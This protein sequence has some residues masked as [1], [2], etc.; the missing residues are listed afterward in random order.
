MEKEYSD[1]ALPIVEGKCPPI[2]EMVIENGEW[3][4]RWYYPEPDPDYEDP[5]MIETETYYLADKEEYYYY[6]TVC[7][8]CGTQ[9]QAYGKDNKNIRNYC[10]GCGKR[11]E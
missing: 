2:H 8:G 4:H 5:E 1:H 7:K 6:P 10:P 3:K 9:F 11:L